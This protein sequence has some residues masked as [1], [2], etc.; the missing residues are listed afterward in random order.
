MRMLACGLSAAAMLSVPVRAAPPAPP[1]PEPPAQ[2]D[3]ITVEGRPPPVP[4][5]R[6]NPAYPMQ[7]RHRWEEGCVVLQFTVRPDGKT[8]DFTVLESKPIG[9]F[10]K[11]V[12]G[13]VFKWRYDPAPDA[14]TVV[15]K[16]EFRSSAMTSEPRYSVRTLSKTPIGLDAAGRPRYKLDMQLQG[17]SPPKCKKRM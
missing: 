14:R 2:F 6:L 11:A 17:Y 5:V 12:I 4:R 15:E 3:P 16:F 10:E 9:V 1:S 8:D 13:A 7:A